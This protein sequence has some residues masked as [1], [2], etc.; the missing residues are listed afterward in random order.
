VVK[1]QVRKTRKRGVFWRKLV[2]WDA[3]L[4]AIPVNEFLLG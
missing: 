3:V 2:S 1:V 4:G